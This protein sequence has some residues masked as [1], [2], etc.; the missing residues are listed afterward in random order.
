MNPTEVIASGVDWQGSPALSS[1]P[2]P[3]LLLLLLGI[4]KERGNRV[5]EYARS[6]EEKSV[7][8]YSIHHSP[9]LHGSPSSISLLPFQI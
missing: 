3:P 2:F 1:C 8:G 6:R 9:L 5:E 4:E 7:V